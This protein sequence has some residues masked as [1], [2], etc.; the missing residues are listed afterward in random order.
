MIVG[1]RHLRSPPPQ[2]PQNHKPFHEQPRTILSHIIGNGLALLL[3][4]MRLFVNFEGSLSAYL[5]LLTYG[6]LA[7]V[8]FSSKNVAHGFAVTTSFA[9]MAFGSLGPAICAFMAEDPAVSRRW[10]L[11]SYAA[12][13]GA[14]VFFRVLALT[15]MVAIKS[16][17]REAWICM[18]WMSWFVPLALADALC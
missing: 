8:W 15:L 13:W 17:K 1:L 9:F 16:N 12:L 11:K 3:G 10:F 14:G 18:I 5:L 7:S 2:Y 6:S 4:T